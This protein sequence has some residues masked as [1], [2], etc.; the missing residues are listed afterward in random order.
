MTDSLFPDEPFRFRFSARPGDARRFFSPSADH[1]QRLRLR[2]EILA[3]HRERHCFASAE[4]GPVIAE[5]CEWAGISG[6]LEDLA[7]HW[8]QDFLLLL[9][10]V[11]VGGAVCFPSSWTPR[12]TL[13]RPVQDIHGAVPTLNASLGARI[14]NFLA[15]IRSER[16]WERVNWGLSACADLN[17]HPARG[18]PVMQAP[19]SLEAVWL[20]REDQ[21]LCRLPRTQALVFGIQVTTAPLATLLADSATCQGLHTAL[22]TMPEDVAVYKNI[23]PVRQKLL[24]LVKS[25]GSRARDC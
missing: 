20:R 18:L 6:G 9:P 14:S 3:A 21:V 17:Q 15:G 10:D 22:A 4:A 7:L 5:C 13:G 12:E 25:A 23:A 16:S 8:E 1:R 2:A 11:V 24:D 19:L